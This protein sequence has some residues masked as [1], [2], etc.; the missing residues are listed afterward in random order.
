VRRR[1]ATRP[2]PASRTVRPSLEERNRTILIAD[3]DDATRAGFAA[4][5]TDSEYSV[6]QAANG[7]EAILHVRRH[8]PDLVVMDVAMPVLD[9]LE[10]AQ[11]LKRFAETAHIPII[12]ISGNAHPRELDLMRAVCHAVLGKPCDPATLLRT[13][14]E[15]LPHDSEIRV[16]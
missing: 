13:I 2:A 10:A 6:L 9:G 12:G 4:L 7:G 5:L 14:E 1:L 8:R 15:A 11:S 3:D 16:A